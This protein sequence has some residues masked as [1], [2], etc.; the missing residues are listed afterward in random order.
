[1]KS[2]VSFITLAIISGLLVYPAPGATNEIHI[3]GIYSAD[4]LRGARLGYRTSAL[5]P[6]WLD[7]AGAPSLAFES[8]VN[9]WQN[10]NNSSDSITAFSISPVLSWQLN[11]SARPLFLEAGIGGSYIDQTQIGNRKLSTRFQFEDRVGLAWQYNSD[12]DARISLQYTH[13][14]NADIE[15]PNDGLDFF[16]VYWVIPL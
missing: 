12:S 10:S 7:W 1:M 5:Q 6:S 15:Q 8:A 16:S 2:V 3:G 4:Q 14:S 13:Y 11:Q 9:F